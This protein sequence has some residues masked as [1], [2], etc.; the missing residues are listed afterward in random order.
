MQQYVIA[1]IV[2]GASMFIPLWIGSKAGELEERTISDFFVQSRSMSA[3]I[4]FFTVQ[5]TWWSA[6]AFLGASSNYY[7]NGP[8]YWTTLAW[9]VLFG[10]LF[11]LL[12]KRIWFYGK[13]RGYLTATDFFLDLY[14]FKPLGLLVTLIMMI[15]TIP[16]FE[17]QITGGT[18]LIEVISAGLIPRQMGAFLFTAVIV[19][20]VWTGGLRAV[21]WADVFYE[22]LIIVSA[23]L[24]ILFVISQHEGIIP[25]FAEL[26]RIK[27]EA[28]TLPGHHQNAG[29]DLW[30]SMFIIV[31]IGALMA[32]PLWTRMYAAREAKIFDRLPF[33]L[34][35]ISI[36]NLAPMLI[37][38]SGILILPDLAM[39]DALLPQYILRYAPYFIAYIILI[40][41]AAA[42]MSTANSQ[43][44]SISITYTIDIHRRYLR[45]D[46]NERG[47][48]TT[49]RIV[50]VIFALLSYLS[51]LYF[52]GVIIQLGLLAL[53]GTSQ[54][55]IPVCGALF[56][57]R[58]HGIG[59]FSG[60][61]TGLVLLTGLHYRF[62]FET[63]D[64]A[65]IGLAGNA[66][67]FFV[68]SHLLPVQ[69]A[70]AEKITL[71]RAL[72]EEQ[73]SEDVTAPPSPCHKKDPAMRRRRS[74][75]Y[76]I[77]L[78]GFL[79]IEFPGIFFINRIDPW[80]LGLPFLYGFVLF[81]WVIMT[82]TLLY[83]ALTSWGK[84]SLM[85]V[86]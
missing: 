15:F 31:P 10:L 84:R 38:Y 41:G 61:L 85:R 19:I 74:G 65:L 56:W 54:L 37:G 86:R 30:I 51:Y 69:K 53:S 18:Y 70:K 66:L 67:V 50:I 21:A 13:E 52:P 2:I 46:M 81:I 34:A 73:T 75:I 83:A 3:I 32:P 20:Y 59:A 49:G 9:D 80:V 8:V 58:S 47:L 36:L 25:L 16:Y 5:A 1:I 7:Q 29:P 35:L 43:I 40:G 82:L 6:F 68:A 77:L 63:S 44:H 28:L 39:A 42:A 57:K 26:T 62:G 64:A 14:G 11:Y 27:P 78:V 4:L 55:L 60:L 17:L 71:L 48:I 45:P 79:L 33:F 72:Y 76:G 12:G 23:L 24:G 22:F